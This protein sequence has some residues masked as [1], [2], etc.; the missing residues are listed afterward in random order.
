MLK[1]RPYSL[2][3]T[4]KQLNKSEMTPLDLPNTGVYAS[5]M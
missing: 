1:R 2:K 4:Y 5:R 3:D